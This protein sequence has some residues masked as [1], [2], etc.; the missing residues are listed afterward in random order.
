VHFVG[1]YDTKLVEYYY[2]I[3]IVG[4]FYYVFIFLKSQSL[5]SYTDFDSIKFVYNT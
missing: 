4:V 3:T 5:C 1:F 2:I